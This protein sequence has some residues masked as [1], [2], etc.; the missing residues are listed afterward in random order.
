M[1]APYRAAENAEEHFPIP[2]QRPR[3]SFRALSRN[4]LFAIGQ[5]L[6]M[7]VCLFLAYRLLVAQ[8]GLAQLGLWSLLMTFGTLANFTDVSG[9]SAL[10]RTVARRDIEFPGMDQAAIV[11]TVLLTSL[12]IN[13]VIVALLLGLGG[14]A[15]NLWIESSQRDS[16]V[17]L[18]PWVA[19]IALLAPLALG[20]SATLDGLYR[21][22]LKAVVNASAAVFGLICAW[23]L[24]PVHGVSGFA[25][26]QIAQLLFIVIGAWV[27]LNR[28]VPNFGWFPSR[29][30]PSIFR[31]TTGYALRTNFVGLFGL[32]FEPLVKFCVNGAGGTIAVGQYELASRLILQVR[33][34]ITSAAAPLLPVLASTDHGT[35]E[36][37]S[38]TLMR[39][40]NVALLAALGAIMVS[41]LAAP[42]VSL[43]ILGNISTDILQ[44]N[45]I[46]AFGWGMNLMSLPFYLAAQSQGRLRWNLAMHA[47]LAVSVLGAA[48]L[49]V[50]VIGVMGVLLAVLFGLSLGAAI[51]II[52][53]GY[54]FGQLRALRKLVGKFLLCIFLCGV[55]C[56]SAWLLVPYVATGA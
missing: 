53:N 11:H 3:I 9:A 55:L 1:T 17:M 8:T 43:A 23:W 29:W 13:F 16:A 45:I 40:Q 6:V 35:D 52:G 56:S 27:L 31:L 33:A 49:L 34:L 48:F 2:S 4:S 18:L 37:F 41:L 54:S 50:P 26:A 15:I 24:I 12:A 14:M 28:Q 46:L 32:F 7:T 10:A 42:L 36:A 20:L 38:D 44:M 25:L 51:T 30:H 39:S 22:D 21:S 47:F 5:S 19:V